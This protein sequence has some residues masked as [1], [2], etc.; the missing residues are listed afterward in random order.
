[1]ARQ[2]FARTVIKTICSVDYIDQ[3][4][5]RHR[6]V[7]VVLFGDYDIAT[8]QKAAIKSLNAKGG[9]VNS[10]RHES[11]YGKMNIKEFAKYCEKTNFKE[12]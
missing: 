3:N 11:F 1:M 5:D 2:T 6:D 12:W 4:N 8:A 10:V 9:I 7:E